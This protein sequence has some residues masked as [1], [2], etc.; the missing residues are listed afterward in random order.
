VRLE[1]VQHVVQ[2][3]HRRAEVRARHCGDKPAQRSRPVA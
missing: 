1:V 3:P 2:Q